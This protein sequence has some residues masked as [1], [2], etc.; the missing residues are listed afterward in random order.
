[1]YAVYSIFTDF[2]ER[3]IKVWGF[4]KIIFSPSNFPSE[5][6]ELKNKNFIRF[7]VG[8]QPKTGKPKNVE[9]FV[10]QKPSEAGDETKSQRPFNKEEEEIVKEVIKKT[11]EAIDFFLKEGLE[12]TMSQ[13][14]K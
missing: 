7:R 5:I 10:L 4:A 1:M 13:F 12:K 2:P 11:A 9:K 14:N 6:K 8:I 3:F